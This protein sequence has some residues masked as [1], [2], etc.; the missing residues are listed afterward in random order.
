M[1]RTFAF[2]AATA[3]GAW[4]VQE[5]GFFADPVRGFFA[6]ADG[7]GGRGAGDLAVKSALSEIRQPMVSAEG[8][9]FS[10]AVRA[11]REAFAKAHLQI[12]E[13]NR[14]LPTAARGGCSLLSAAIAT[15]GQ[16][17]LTQCGACVA[18]LVRGGRIS[19]LLL[20]QSGPREEF[21]PY[22]P[23]QALGLADPLLPE[24]RTF[25]LE[26]GDILVLASGGLEWESESFHLE[27][28]SQLSVRS[29]GSDLSAAANHVLE[30]SSLAAQ[31]WNRTLILVER[32]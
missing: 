13:K 12:T 30:N 23:E 26:A 5:D 2:G 18:L 32:M 22:L 24:S 27:L 31:S 29:L 6:V 15:S 9:L 3:Q 10:P 1:K 28:I 21:Q 8:T 16:V 20:P 4:P 19:P 25:I 11:Q 7:F 17:S 14:P